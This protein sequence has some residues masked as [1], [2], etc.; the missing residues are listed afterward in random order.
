MNYSVYLNGKLLT[1]H[2]ARV[3]KLPLNRVWPGFQRPLEQ[4]EIG[5]FVTFDMNAPV[6]LRIEISDEIE[7]VALRPREFCIKHR[8]GKRCIEIE[9]TEPRLFTVEVNGHHEALCVFAKS[10]RGRVW[11]KNANKR[12]RGRAQPS[13]ERT[14]PR[15]GYH[16]LPMGR[17]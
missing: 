14:K 7:R 10:L 8:V 1:V 11:A 6:H 2:S 5:Y 9:L 17:W 4:T 16:R 12:P 13:A 15:R 3:S